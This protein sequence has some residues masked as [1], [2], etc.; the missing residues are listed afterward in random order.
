MLY[1]YTYRNIISLMQE[2]GKLRKDQIVKFFAKELAPMQTKHLLDQLEI[3]HLLI[4]DE[5]EDTYRFI[6]APKYKPDWEKRIIHAFWVLVSIG[7]ND[8]V[9][10]LRCRYPIQIAFITPD[11]NIYD[12]TIITNEQEAQL[13]QVIFD[14]QTPR[15]SNGKKTDDVVVHIGV[16]YR[17]SDIQLL[18]KYGFDVCAMIDQNTH[19]VKYSYFDEE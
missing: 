17:E 1:Q 10:I 11:N 6:G 3:N 12:I 7:S 13:A 16:V 14:R 18:D 9:Q 8:I 5:D 2:M 19:E 15:E 4:Y